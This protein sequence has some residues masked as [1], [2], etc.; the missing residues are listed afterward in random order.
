[1]WYITL[2]GRKGEFV[3]IALRH[4][5][6][7]IVLAVNYKN[8][9][10]ST[11]SVSPRR[12]NK[13]GKTSRNLREARGNRWHYTWSLQRN[14]EMCCGSGKTTREQQ[15]KAVSSTLS[16]KYGNGLRRWY[17]IR[18]RILKKSSSPIVGLLISHPPIISD[19]T[20]VF[21]SFFPQFLAYLATLSI[22]RLRLLY[23]FAQ[24]LNIEALVLSFGQN[25]LQSFI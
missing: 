16:F 1:M 7:K 19:T 20:S 18:F 13:T 11:L 12:T 5:Y 22:V 8:I 10:K 14:F 15:V 3:D 21:K 23:S 6:T 25:A 4:F 9:I 17:R 24:L 2:C